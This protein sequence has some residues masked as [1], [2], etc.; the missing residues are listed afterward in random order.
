MTRA[1]T[2]YLNIFIFHLSEAKYSTG[3]H[4]LTTEVQRWMRVSA[5]AG[6]LK[7]Y[8]IFKPKNDI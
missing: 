8:T 4:R 3:P 1:L 6:K 5:G 2:N 7:M